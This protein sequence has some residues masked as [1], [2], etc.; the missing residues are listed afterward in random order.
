[1]QLR[2][3][4]VL[5]VAAA[6]LPLAIV[7]SQHAARSPQRLVEGVGGQIRERNGAPAPE[8]YAGLAQ[9]LRLTLL[10]LA[11]GSL[12]WSGAAELGA[13]DVLTGRTLVEEVRDRAPQAACS[14]SD[15]RMARSGGSERQ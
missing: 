12:G 14:V 13:R 6:A 2:L 10:S 3:S 5:F 7:L 15:P 9:L 8:L 1:M 11:Q 4:V